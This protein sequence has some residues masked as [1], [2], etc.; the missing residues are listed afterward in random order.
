MKVAVPVE[1]NEVVREVSAIDAY[2]FC[3]YDQRTGE[4]AAS[5]GLFFVVNKS[6]LY[7]AVPVDKADLLSHEEIWETHFAETF[8]VGFNHYPRG[9]ILYNS[10]KEQFIISVDRC[11]ESKLIKRIMDIFYLVESNCKTD[12]NEFY[13]CHKC[14][15]I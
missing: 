8:D 6:I 1:Y 5:A 7:A 3:A 9:R 2:N 12:V 10:S 4:K 15:L 14:S 11:V 13:Q